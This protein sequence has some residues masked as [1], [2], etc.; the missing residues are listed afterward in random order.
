MSDFDFFGKR[1]LMQRMAE[2]VDIA[3]FGL[4]VRLVR[5][6]RKTHDDDIAYKISGALANELFS[7]PH[8]GPEG[9]EFARENSGFLRSE[10]TR[11]ADDQ[12]T[13]QVLTQVVRVK[14]TIA[15]ASGPRDEEAIMRPMEKLKELGLFIPGGDAPSPDTFIPL[16]QRYYETARQ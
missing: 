10:M 9:E 5:H 3:K 15:Y 7:D 4:A 8:G 12:E 2:A 11:L 6:Y 1:C 13:C 14:A 16:A